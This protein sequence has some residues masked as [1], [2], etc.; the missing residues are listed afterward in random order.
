MS[1]HNAEDE[2]NGNQMGIQ[3][4]P[5]SRTQPKLILKE[6]SKSGRNKNK[7]QVNE[8]IIIKKVI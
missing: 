8:S 7:R 6:S 3:E 2:I 5:K 4:K 1:K